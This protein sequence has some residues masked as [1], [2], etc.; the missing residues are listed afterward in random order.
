M[1]NKQ[2][3]SKEELITEVM[4]LFKRLEQHQMHYQFEPW[5]KLDVPL[6]QL[7]SLF[8]IHIK[9]NINVRH[10]AQYLDVTPGNVT[11]IVDRLV[12]QGL[13]TRSENPED[14]RIVLLELTDKGRETINNIHETG[15]SHMKRILG[16]MNEEDISA[17]IRGVSGFIEAAK[18]DQED[19]TAKESENGHH[20]GIPADLREHIVRHHL[21]KPS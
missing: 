8:L 13:V 21:M 11:S 17:L 14:R 19:S 6:A 16:R 4:E 7:K 1:Y 12:G 3:M 10:L 2:V 15:I 20:A 9:G 18:G 5:R